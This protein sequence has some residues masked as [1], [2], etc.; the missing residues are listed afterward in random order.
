M[1]GDRRRPAVKERDL[2]A[3]SP[4]MQ[5]GQR[6]VRRR[7]GDRRY[8][9]A[10]RTCGTRR[11]AGCSCKERGVGRS[12]IVLYDPQLAT[13][14]ANDDLSRRNRCDATDTRFDVELFVDL[15][16]A[17]RYTRRAA[18]S[19]CCRR[20]TG[21]CRCTG[22]QETGPQHEHCD[23]ATH[24][25]RS[26]RP[27]RAASQLRHRVRGHALGPSDGW[28]GVSRRRAVVRIRRTRPR[29]RPRCSPSRAPRR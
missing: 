22:P 24:A 27:A 16:A 17:G 11:R 4:G 6:G 25:S 2:Q 14:F 1:L 23:Q 10:T 15:G 29:R 18:I 26:F 19:R 12:M 9:E 20:C 8:V 7:C 5:V 28:S 3:Q 13:R 21:E